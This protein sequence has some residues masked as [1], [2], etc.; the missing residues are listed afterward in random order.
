MELDAE[1]VFL[2]RGRYL[3]HEGRRHGVG[4]VR[5]ELHVYQP[6]RAVVVARELEVFVEPFASAV[7]RGHDAARE[8]RAHSAREHGF[9]HAVHEEVHVGEAGRAGRE[10]FHERELRADVCRLRVELVFDGPDFLLQP[11]HERQ[12][13]AEAAQHG[14][15]GVSVGVDE[16]GE[17]RRAAAS[18]E[19]R[20][21]VK[22]SRGRYF[23]YFR[24]LR[25][26]VAEACAL[27]LRVPEDDV[28]IELRHFLF[29]PARHVLFLLGRELLY[30]Y[31]E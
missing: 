3:C 29:S 19:G 5:A 21:A 30:R 22:R 10:H 24:A 17:H 25:E 13:F 11:F 18:V 31:A 14:H 20:F 16:A 8:A 12:L 7:L 15:R 27:A 26:H 1:A 23:R 28:F 9:R 6:I 2:R 4:R